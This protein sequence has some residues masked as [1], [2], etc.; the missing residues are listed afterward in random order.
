M[1]IIRNSV[2]VNK[3]YL[4]NGLEKQLYNCPKELNYYQFMINEINNIKKQFEHDLIILQTNPKYIN[5][6]IS[7]SFKTNDPL[8]IKMLKNSFIQENSTSIHSNFIFEKNYGVKILNEIVLYFMKIN[9]IDINDYKYIK[10]SVCFTPYP[11]LWK[12]F[13]YIKNPVLTF[14]INIYT[15]K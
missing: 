6:M 4:L 11:I 15:P 8:I 7:Y 12:L 13:N 1:D 5:R 2:K 9:N 3:Q 10:S 14:S